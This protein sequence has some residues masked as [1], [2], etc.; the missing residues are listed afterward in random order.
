MASRLLFLSTA[1]SHSASGY[2]KSLVEGKVAHHNQNIIDIVGTKLDVLLNGILAGTKF[3]REAMAE[4]LKFAFNIAI[5]YP[6]VIS[7][8][9][10]LYV[11]LINDYFFRL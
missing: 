5:H 1:S 8:P 9:L 2:I 7:F 3:S 11:W 4:L 6:K 10:S